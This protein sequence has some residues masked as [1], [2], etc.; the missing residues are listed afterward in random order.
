MNLGQQQ[1]K[2]VWEFLGFERGGNFGYLWIK[3]H[4]FIRKTCVR[5]VF[6][7]GFHS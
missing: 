3:V 2:L 5:L 4:K 6:E 7:E 1:H